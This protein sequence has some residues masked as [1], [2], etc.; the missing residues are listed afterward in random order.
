VKRDLVSIMFEPWMLSAGL[1]SMLGDHRDPPA[2]IIK[3]SGRPQPRP[4]RKRG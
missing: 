1:D 3:K 4:Q 2:K